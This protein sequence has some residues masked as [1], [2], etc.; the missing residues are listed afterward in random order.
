MIKGRFIRREIMNP[1]ADL[2]VVVSIDNSYEIKV[3]DNSRELYDY[4]W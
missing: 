3:S 4:P 1:S 2:K